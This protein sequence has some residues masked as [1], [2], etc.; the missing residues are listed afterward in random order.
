MS[1]P[2]H[3]PP[4]RRAE[5][6]PRSRRATRS[7]RACIAIAAIAAIGVGPAGAQAVPGKF[8]GVIPQAT[9]TLEQLQ[10]LKRGGV[11]SIRVPVVWSGIQQAPGGPMD[12]SG[13]DREFEAA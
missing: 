4:R 5:S 1:S 11:D 2:A 3:P 13:V 9:P 8:W 12:W 6:M 10:R 7:L